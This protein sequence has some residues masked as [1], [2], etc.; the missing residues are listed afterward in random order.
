MVNPSFSS[1]FYTQDSKLEDSS[2]ESLPTLLILKTVSD[3]RHWSKKYPICLTLNK[4]QMNFD[5]Y[6]NSKETILTE[7][8]KKSKCSEAD[9]V[10]EK[11]GKGFLRKKKY[12]VQVN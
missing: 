4:D 11:S 6:C 7:E 5:D 12:A 8:D 9:T 3:Y 10:S 2:I 1:K